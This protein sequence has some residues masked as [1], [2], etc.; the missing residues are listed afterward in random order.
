[1]GLFDES[2][3]S[4]ELNERLDQQAREA[5]AELDQKRENITKMKVEAEKSRGAPNWA[6]EKR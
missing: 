4:I 1:M 3:Q 2:E 6:G 5:Q